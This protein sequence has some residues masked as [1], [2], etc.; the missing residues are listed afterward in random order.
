M[1]DAS[2]NIFVY[3][4]SANNKQHNKLDII[5]HILFLPTFENQI[6]MYKYRKLLAITV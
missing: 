1:E 4:V 2:A 3:E 6:D 5:V